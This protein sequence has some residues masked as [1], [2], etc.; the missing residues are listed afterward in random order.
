LQGFLI[1]SVIG[2]SIGLFIPSPNQAAMRE[3]F[4]R[5]TARAGIVVLER[6]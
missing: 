4:A 3:A 1:S 6:R 2:V 5:T